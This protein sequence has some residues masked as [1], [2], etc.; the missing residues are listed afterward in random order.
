M[1][2]IYLILSVFLRIFPAVR[3]Q[4][5]GSGRRNCR[6]EPPLELA[7]WIPLVGWISVSVQHNSEARWLPW[8]VN[9]V[10]PLGSTWLESER[11]QCRNNGSHGRGRNLPPR[12]RLPD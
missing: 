10:N 5:V 1:D 11:N 6:P 3:K 4:S 12:F 7:L 2:L 9:R 8:R